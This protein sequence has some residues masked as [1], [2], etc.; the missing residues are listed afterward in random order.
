MVTLPTGAPVERFNLATPSSGVSRL[1]GS[2]EGSKKEK[3]LPF[4]R[5]VSGERKK[6]VGLKYS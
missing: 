2:A 4:G 6:C 3:V 1:M 5:C